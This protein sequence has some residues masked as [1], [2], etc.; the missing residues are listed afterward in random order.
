MNIALQLATI[1]KFRIVEKD[2]ILIQ[3]LLRS[4]VMMFLKII[5]IYT[6]QRTATIYSFTEP[7]EEFK[8]GGEKT[9]I[10]CLP[11]NRACIN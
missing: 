8:L 10:V 11:L 1:R 3:V 4:L 6:F 5:N 7:P 2:V 9:P